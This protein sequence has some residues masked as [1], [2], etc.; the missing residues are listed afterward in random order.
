RALPVPWTPPRGREV[1]GTLPAEAVQ[2]GRAYA[3]QFPDRPIDQVTEEVATLLSARY[4]GLLVLC[5]FQA[6]T[7]TAEHP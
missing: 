4:S 1:L 5:D 6:M 7:V 3:N 2:V